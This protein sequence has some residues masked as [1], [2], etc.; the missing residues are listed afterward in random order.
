MFSKTVLR[1][2]FNNEISNPDFRTDVIVWKDENDVLKAAIDA[3]F[4][5]DLEKTTPM[6][7]Y[8]GWVLMARSGF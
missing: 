3:S 4:T 6:S 7:D 1:S 5:G 8:L 2:K